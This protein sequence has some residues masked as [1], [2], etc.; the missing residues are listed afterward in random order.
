MT[1]IRNIAAAV[2][3]I[4]SVASPLHAAEGFLIVQQTTTGTTTRKTEVQ[5]ERERMRAEI[6]GAPGGSRIVTFDGPQQILRII[7]VEGKSYTEMTKADADR[8][9]AMVNAMMANMKEKI[10]KLPPEQRAKIEASMGP[11]GLIPG[12]VKPEFRRAGTDMVGK[13]T[14]DKY[15]AFRNEQKVMEV[16]AV[17]PKTLGLTPADFEISKPFAAFFEKVAPQGAHQIVD[18]GTIERH[19]YNGVPVRRVIYRSGNVLATSDVI[20]VRRQSFDASSYDP[21]AGFRKQEL[22][23]GGATIR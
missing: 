6:E 14:C 8:V 10:A 4:G 23:A 1:R 11:A 18:V 2:F 13:W 21:P 16:C 17:D 7:N 20:D 19:G 5:I 12:T 9:G 15:E 22:G 3:V